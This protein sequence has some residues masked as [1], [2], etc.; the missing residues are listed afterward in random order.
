MRRIG[1]Y[2]LN[3]LA[4][5]SLLLCVA[6]VGLWVR[7]S[8]VREIVG[9]GRAGGNSYLAQSIL[10]RLHVLTQFDANASGGWSYA[11]DRLS[12]QAIW[13]GGMSGYPLQVRRHLGVVWQHYDR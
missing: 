9:L 12:P 3:A 4:A 8:W 7:S 6:T 10:G 5:L 13:G 1:P 2:I 11:S